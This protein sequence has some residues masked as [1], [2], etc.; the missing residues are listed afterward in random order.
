MDTCKYCG[1]VEEMDEIVD[2]YG[3]S[4]LFNEEIKHHRTKIYDILDKYGRE[5]LENIREEYI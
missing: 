5:E 1:S 2:D 3:T 4:E